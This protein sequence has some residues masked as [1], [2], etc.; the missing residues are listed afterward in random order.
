MPYS[1][2]PGDF[3]IEFDSRGAADAVKAL[4]KSEGVGSIIDPIAPLCGLHSKFRIIV[5]ES[6]AHRARRVLSSDFTDEELAYLA[7]GELG[8]ED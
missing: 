4:L 3:V 6:M 5:G 8:P 1:I 7:T 2:L